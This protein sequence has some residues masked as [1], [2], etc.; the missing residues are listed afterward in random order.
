M[1]THHQHLNQSETKP[2]LPPSHPRPPRPRRSPCPSTHAFAQHTLPIPFILH[3]CITA[4]V[5]LVFTL[6]FHATLPSRFIVGIST[7]FAVIVTAYG[8]A[9]YILWWRDGVRS[10]D[11]EPGVPDPAGRTVPVPGPDTGSGSAGSGS[12]TK[13]TAE[14][15][16]TTKPR[17]PNSRINRLLSRMKRPVRRLYKIT[18]PTSFQQFRQRL[19]NW[20]NRPDPK[21]KTWTR[22]VQTRNG[23][24]V[25]G[26]V[27]RS[28][29]RQRGANVRAASRRRPY[30]TDGR[31][32]AAERQLHQQSQG[33]R[34]EETGN[35]TELELTTDRRLFSWEGADADGDENGGAGDG[36]EGVNQAVQ[37]PEEPVQEQEQQHEQQQQH[38]Q[39]K[40]QYEDSTPSTHAH[41]Q[42]RYT[43][44]AHPTIEIHSASELD[45]SSVVNA[46]RYEC[47]NDI[48]QEEE[49]TARLGDTRKRA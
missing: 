12:V 10:G 5:I 43:F 19:S 29:R 39:G 23:P 4:S 35:E 16:E 14:T 18:R 9:R 3:F 13:E 36:A 26:G 28:R 32:A 24:A 49:S 8:V 40:Y 1:S 15:G 22:E 30:W 11:L 38:E 33:M 6:T 2:P 44:T 47:G 41:T 7:V 37:R 34:G 21:T 27:G 42:V 17:Y 20:N 46:T 45:V 48:A 31:I 25:A